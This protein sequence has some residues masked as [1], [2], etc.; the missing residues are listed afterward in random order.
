MWQEWDKLEKDE[1][2]LHAPT[3]NILIW[4]FEHCFLPGPGKCFRAHF[5]FSYASL[6]SSHIHWP[7]K[8]GTF[9]LFPL[10]LK[11]NQGLPLLDPPFW[12][13]ICHSLRFS[14]RQFLPRSS[15]RELSLEQHVIRTTQDAYNLPEQTHKTTVWCPIK[16]VNGT[17]TDG[18]KLTN[19]LE[20]VQRM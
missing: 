11:Q 16:W 3:T 17:K 5:I 19:K 2:D 1:E 9:P 15:L 18:C 12:A 14:Q 7:I 10:S 20:Q 4:S 13:K 6:H 8:D